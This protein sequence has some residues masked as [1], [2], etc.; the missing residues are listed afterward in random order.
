MT[1]DVEYVDDVATA[2]VAAV[3]EVDA[4]VAAAAELVADV[5]AA[6]AALAA[7]LALVEAAASPARGQSRARS[8]AVMNDAEIQPR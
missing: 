7:A 1:G 5:E 8:S 3:A 2:R 4:V 6:A